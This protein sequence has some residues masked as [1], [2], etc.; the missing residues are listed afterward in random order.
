MTNPMDSLKMKGIGASVR[1]WNVRLTKNA[2]TLSRR[3][4]IAA[5]AKDSNGYTMFSGKPNILSITALCA[6]SLF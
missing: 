1:I 5:R 4:R 3:M 2:S 6:D